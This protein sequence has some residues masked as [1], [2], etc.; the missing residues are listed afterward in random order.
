[1]S[2]FKKIIV[3]GPAGSGKTSLI[4]TISGY[5]N[6]TESESSGI[7]VW[8]MAKEI[9]PQ[10]NQWIFR[11][12]AGATLSN[13]TPF[14]Y[15]LAT[16][17]ALYII[18]LSNSLSFVGIEDELNWLKTKMPDARVLL[19]ATKSDLISAGEA[20]MISNILP[21]KPNFICSSIQEG[22]T[23]PLWNHLLDTLRS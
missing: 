15:F 20:E 10:V 23:N 1:M 22:G 2:G 6:N 18:D 7:Q 3:C 8:R 12:H 13:N 5:S 9:D 16:H 11:D 17:I 4:R 19:I 21:V 14:S